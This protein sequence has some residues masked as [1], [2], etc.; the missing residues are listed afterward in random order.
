MRMLKPTLAIAALMLA[1]VPATATATGPNYNPGGP[2][3]HPQG[4]PPH[5]HA[6]G[7]FCKGFS[8]KHV[9]GQKGTPFSQCVKAMA[10]ANR[11][12]KLSPGKACKG[13]A[14][15]GHTA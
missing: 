12:H 5:G 8:K 4:P 6:Y 7:F 9:K 3:Y 11:N 2:K 1:M 15:P 13:L 14:K 10:R